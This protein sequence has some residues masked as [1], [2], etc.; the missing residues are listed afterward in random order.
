M[1]CGDRAQAMGIRRKGGSQS[2]SSK[3]CLCSPAVRTPPSGPS[4][5]LASA[6]AQRPPVGKT[7][8]VRPAPPAPLPV[9]NPPPRPLTVGNAPG[10]GRCPPAASRPPPRSAAP[11]RPLCRKPMPGSSGGALCS[12]AA[13]LADTAAAAPWFRALCG[14]LCAAGKGRAARPRLGCSPRMARRLRFGVYL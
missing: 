14:V 7:H 4:P 8:I 6:A 9:A 1:C 3:L 5:S 10:P 12:A 11:C 13:S 2:P